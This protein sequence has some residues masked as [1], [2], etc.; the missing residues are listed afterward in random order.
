MGMVTL[1]EIIPPEEPSKSRSCFGGRGEGF[2][3]CSLTKFVS[4]KQ[5]V[6]PESIRDVIVHD[7]GTE[8]EE[9]GIISESEEGAE[10]LSR[11]IGSARRGSTQSTLRAMC[12]LL[13]IFPTQE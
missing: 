4:M 9:V 5:W 1:S 2:K 13:S 3:L 6:E 10:A 7:V 12:G 11:T 8:S